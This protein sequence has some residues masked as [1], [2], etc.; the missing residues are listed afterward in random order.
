[1]RSF[2]VTGQT[3]QHFVSRVQRSLEDHGLTDNVSVRCE[4]AEIVARIRWMGTTELRYRTDALDD[5]F[6]ATL[7]RHRVA[8]LHG[9]FQHAFEERLEGVL[10]KVGA[11]LA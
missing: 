6:R 2:E 9:A 3:P 5:G 10:A 11:K 4:G 1:M 8:P 7:D